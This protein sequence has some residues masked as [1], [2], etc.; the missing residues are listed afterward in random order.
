MKEKDNPCLVIQHAPL[1]TSFASTQANSMEQKPAANEL[2]SFQN[3]PMVERRQPGHRLH[4]PIRI[5]VAFETTASDKRSGFT[6]GVADAEALAVA[7]TKLLQ[8]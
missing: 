8:G 2:I 1:T 4:N 6:V 3:I 7:I 5:T